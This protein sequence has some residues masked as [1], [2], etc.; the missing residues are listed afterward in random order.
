MADGQDR[1]EA[2]HDDKVGGEYPPDHLIGAE[3]YGAAGADP[4]H[5]E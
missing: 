1:A 3:A 5:H 4:A 2:L